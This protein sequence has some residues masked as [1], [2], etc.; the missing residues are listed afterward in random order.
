[1]GVKKIDAYLELINRKCIKA[2]SS[3]NTKKLFVCFYDNIQFALMRTFSFKLAIK[4]IK[5][6]NRIG[7]FLL[8]FAV[9]NMRY[10]NYWFVR[11]K[12]MAI[13]C[14]FVKQAGIKWGAQV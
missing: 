5:L 6:F 13:A 4:K 12:V 9:L 14:R 11:F 7:C 8:S 3:F 2:L 1:M 10:I